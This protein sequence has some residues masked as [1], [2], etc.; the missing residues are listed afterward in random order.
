[1]SEVRP[2]LLPRRTFLF[3]PPLAAW[4]SLRSEGLMT[5]L[6]SGINCLWRKTREIKETR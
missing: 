4:I 1:M 2:A 6:W 5:V 3:A